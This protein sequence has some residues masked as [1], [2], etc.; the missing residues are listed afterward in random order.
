MD[1]ISDQGRIIHEAGEAEASGVG[2]R[3]PDRPVQRKFTK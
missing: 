1:G 2:T 3:A